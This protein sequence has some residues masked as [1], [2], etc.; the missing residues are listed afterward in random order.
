MSTNISNNTLKTAKDLRIRLVELDNYFDNCS[1]NES[2]INKIIDDN[3]NSKS[4]SNV[5]TLIEHLIFRILMIKN[6]E[7]SH[8]NIM[9]NL[10]DKI[11]NNIENKPL[12]DNLIICIRDNLGLY[13]YN[14]KKNSDY[15]S[16]IRK[17]L[18]LTI[19]GNLH[20]EYTF[21]PITSLNQIKIKFVLKDHEEKEYKIITIFNFK[22]KKYLFLYKLSEGNNNTFSTNGINGKNGNNNIIN[23]INSNNYTIV[24]F[25]DSIKNFFELSNSE[26]NNN[27][28]ILDEDIKKFI[29]SGKTNKANNITFNSLNT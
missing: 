24:E 16:K 28:N 1:A 11:K 19:N 2:N 23:G 25:N 15:R 14:W 21:S 12:K 26:S 10:I 4:Y 13:K 7:T 20:E 17:L 6:L 18:P 5:K 27:I 9:T 29:M 22:G 8:F 3:I